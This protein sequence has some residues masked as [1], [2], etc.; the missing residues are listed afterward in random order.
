MGATTFSTYGYGKTAQ[1]AFRQAVEQA[2]WDYGHGGYTGTIAEKHSYV[3]ARVP[4]GVRCTS[5]RFM[6]LLDEYEDF[7]ETEYLRYRLEHATSAMEKRKLEAQIRKAT[8][9]FESWKRKINPALFAQIESVYPSYT[10]KWG[11]AVAVELSGKELSEM[12]KRL[13]LARTQKKVYV[14]FGWA[15]C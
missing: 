14:F 12:K 8:K 3:V 13:G 4:A 6:T 5:E 9:R 10:D 11:P 1:D 2:Q 7:N 15:S